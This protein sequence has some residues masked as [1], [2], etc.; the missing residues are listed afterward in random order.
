MALISG[1]TGACGL[2][3]GQVNVASGCIF[4]FIHMSRGSEEQ[5]IGSV[6][7]APHSAT[8]RG[9]SRSVRNDDHE[10]RLQRQIYRES[11]I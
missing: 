10:T 9:S 7:F 5:W 11:D 6:Q 4:A 2:A 3:G 8:R 1:R